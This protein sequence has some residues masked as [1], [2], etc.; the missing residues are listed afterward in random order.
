V[1]ADI[2]ARSSGFRPARETLK[3]VR[4]VP[5][6]FPD[7]D[8]ATR[9]GGHPIDRVCLVHGPSNHGKTV[10]AHGLGLSFLR[11]GHMYCLIDAEMTSPITWLE[12]LLREHADSAGFLA[13]R[14]KSY[15]QAVDDV[16]KVCAGLVEARVK[17]RVPEDTSALFVVDSVRKLV[18]EDIVARI[19]KMGAEGEKGSVD[20]YGGR[21]A[22][23]RAA[24]NAAWLDELTPLMYHAGCA[25]LF[26]S[27]ESEDPDADATARRFGRAYKVGGG[28]ALL[29]DSSLAM[30]VEREAFI[31]P[32]GRRS[33]DEEKRETEVAVGERHRVTIHKTKVAAKQDREEVCYFHTSNGAGAVPEGF[34]RARDVLMLAEELGVAKKSGAWLQFRKQRWQGEARFVATVKPETLYEMEAACRARFADDSRGVTVG[35]EV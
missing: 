1:F 2:A 15:E 19:K 24:L 22:Q 23:M 26:I 33:Q 25:I 28:K 6:I 14:P 9:V 11:R 21:A 16:R 4:A 10:M 31:Y 3:R 17:S 18:P 30:R 27:R 7:Y 8:R 32:N 5:T 20:G 12:A 13:S 29:F 35:G 34:D